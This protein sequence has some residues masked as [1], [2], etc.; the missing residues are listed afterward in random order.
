MTDVLSQTRA[1]LYQRVTD[2]IAQAIEAGA[3]KFI[4]PWHGIFGR[5]RNAATGT[6]YQGINTLVLWAAARNRKYVSWYWATYR[7]W[8]ELG[9]RV[10]KG[11]KATAIVLYKQLRVSAEDAETGEPVDD[12]RPV[13]RMFFVFNAAQVEGWSEPDRSP[14]RVFATHT[15]IQ[16][17]IE[18]TGAEIRYGD[19]AAYHRAKDIITIPDQSRFIETPTSS[20]TESYYSTVF[21]ELVHW[22]G[23]HWRLDR[24]L[25][26]RF[27][28]HDYAME[29]LIAE[30]GAAYLCAEFLVLHAPRKDHAAYIGEWLE[31]LKGDKRA[32]FAAASKANQAVTF[33]LAS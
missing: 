9:A 2:E 22:S 32:I 3:G 17:F 27:G 19:M 10:V 25:S 6:A 5:P 7:Q 11:E 26:S 33:L 15:E 28:S 29:E 18:A 31:V 8:H 12:Y 21:H 23:A 4:M 24:N 30:L 1:D 13:V 16:H 20:P 14:A